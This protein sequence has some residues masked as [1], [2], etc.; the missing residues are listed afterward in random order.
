MPL[1]LA[2]RT[3]DD[4][5]QTTDDGRRTTYDGCVCFIILDQRAGRDE[6]GSVIGRQHRSSAAAASAIPC[7]SAIGHRPSSVVQ[8]RGISFAMGCVILMAADGARNPAAQ[9]CV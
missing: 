6:I 7:S 8:S 3:T 4:R 2:L 1:L 5:R 9:P